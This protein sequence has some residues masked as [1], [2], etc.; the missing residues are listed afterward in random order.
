MTAQ[1]RKKRTAKA[2]L[3]TS[4][5]GVSSV[6]GLTA[7]SMSYWLEKINPDAIVKLWMHLKASAEAAL[8]R[9]TWVQ[10]ASGTISKEGLVAD[11]TACTTHGG[12]VLSFTV[13]DTS[14]SSGRNRLK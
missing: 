14:T 5:S 10:W 9:T 4:A 6:E 2:G 1:K 8:P 7:P 3:Q 12:F 13:A 11:V